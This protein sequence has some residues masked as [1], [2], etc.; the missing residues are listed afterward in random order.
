MDLREF[1]GLSGN[2]FFFPNGLPCQ[3]GKWSSSEPTVPRKTYCGRT[4]FWS[5]ETVIEPE[6]SSHDGNES[7]KLPS[8]DATGYKTSL[9]DPQRAG[10]AGVEPIL[11]SGLASLVMS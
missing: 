6:S 8:S 5:T 4:V 7:L 11:R 2:E 10:G 3:W 1:G 9:K